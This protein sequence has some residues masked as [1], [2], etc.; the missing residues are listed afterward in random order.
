MG[1]RALDGHTR[2][3]EGHNELVECGFVKGNETP[4]DTSFLTS[5]PWSSYKRKGA[6]PRGGIKHFLI[7]YWET[8]SKESLR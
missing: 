1:V 6:P 3:T 7:R 8:K 2:S 5:N 4:R